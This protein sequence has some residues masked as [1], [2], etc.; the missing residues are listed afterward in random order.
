MNFDQISLKCRRKF[1]EKGRSS[2]NSLIS[3]L[4]VMQM[5]EIDNYFMKQEEPV[6]G[7]LLFLRSYILAFENEITEGWRYSMPFYFIKGKR[8]CYLWVQ[9]KTGLPYVGIVDGK[10]INHPHL[11]QEDRSRMKILLLDPKKDIP[12]KVLRSVLHASLKLYK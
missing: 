9:K 3:G 11:I 5:S 1:F 6:K 10:L 12:L 4:D 8:F 2:C 7:C